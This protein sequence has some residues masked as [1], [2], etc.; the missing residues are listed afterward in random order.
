MKI[1]VLH[2]SYEGSKAP[3]KGLDPDC[4]PGRYLPDASFSNFQI[5]KATSAKQIMEIAAQGFDVFLNLCDGAWDEDR[6]GIEVVQTLEKLNVAFTGAGTGFYDPT[7]E[8]M[9]MA[10]YASDVKVPAYMYVRSIE[11]EK[12]VVEKLRFPMIVKHPQ[13]YGSVGM[14]K[15]SRVTDF[16]GLH[17][18]LERMLKQFGGALVEEFI[19]G[20]EYTVL[21]TEPR[22]G[23]DTPLTYPPVEFV[24]SDDE[25]FKHFNLKWVD[26]QKMDMRIVEDDEELI[27][28]LREAAALTFESLVGSG[29]ARCDFRVNPEGEVF[30]LEINPNGAVFYPEGQF[31]GADF[32]LASVPMGHRDFLEHLLHCAKRRQKRGEVNWE[33]T[34]D[35]N[36]GF[37]M[38]AAC[39]IPTGEIVVCYEEQP[40]KLVSR[41]HVE[42][43]WRGLKRQWFE[44]YAYP[45]TDEIFQLWSDNPEEW[46]PINHSCEPNTWLQGLDII[47]RRDIKMGEELTLDY[48]TFYDSAME[49]FDCTCGASECRGKIHGDDYQKP[50]IVGRYGE[51]VSSFVRRHKRVQAAPPIYPFAELQTPHRGLLALRGWKANEV[52]CPIS[53]GSVKS[54][55]TRWSIQLD[56]ETHA[57][58]GPSPLC[59]VNHSCEPNVSFDIETSELRAI[60]DIAP[61]D[62]LVCFYPA[63]EWEIE[64]T[65]ECE[66]VSNRCVG[67]VRG[68]A[69]LDLEQLVQY[70]LSHVIQRYLEQKSQS[71]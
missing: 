42:K 63:T 33:W 17:R 51:H 55:P 25:T 16:Q 54:K 39:D 62:E 4:D 34:F 35:P 32:S 57:E 7:R 26:W 53:W 24:F 65:F 48:A 28:S 36:T 56:N 30:L 3:F 68:A 18:E 58:P 60:R 21:V 29:Y 12:R 15:D 46:R 67:Q 37:G 23:E 40:C 20:R 47:A 2:P 19:E 66:C 64:E 49:S 22:D 8:S 69:F 71:K 27:A 1:A 44:Q 59:L 38:A 13:S 61:G 70:P 10:A 6:P 50:E 43:N 9:K 52:I 5:F 11:Q 45:I 31:G 14:T 41:Q